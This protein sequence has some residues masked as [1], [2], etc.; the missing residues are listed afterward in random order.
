[1]GRSNGFTLI[2]LLVVTS[3]IALLSSVVMANL[4]AARER[5]RVASIRSYESQ[6]HHAM[7]DSAVGIWDFDEC[8]GTVAADRSGFGNDAELKNGATFSSDTVSGEGCSLSLDGV[9]DHARAL[10]PILD[11]SSSITVSFWMYVETQASSYNRMLADSGSGINV[12]FTST[13]GSGLYGSIGN[14]ASGWIMQNPDLRG[15]WNHIVLTADASNGRIRSYLNG[16]FVSSQNASFANVTLD[17][18][19]FG[20]ES[21]ASGYFL[22]GNLDDVRIY[23]R[24]LSAAEA[25]RVYALSLP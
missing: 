20:S 2:E 11:S 15:K 23:S 18:L 7:G 12:Y 21:G 10:G 13:G 19:Y 22:K 9:N 24:A 16:R 25:G 17:N 1:M 5:A 4:N 6:L 8:A 14:T 3:I